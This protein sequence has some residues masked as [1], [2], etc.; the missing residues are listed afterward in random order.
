MDNLKDLSTWRQTAVK[1]GYFMEL[2]EQQ[3][4]TKFRECQT[5]DKVA[6]KA[7]A[8]IYFQIADP[9]KAAYAIDVLPDTLQETCL[10]VLRSTIGCHDFDD[11]FLKRVEINRTVTKE[12]EEKSKSWGIQLREVIIGQVAYNPEVQRALEEKRIA[13]A[14]KAAR[15]IESEAISAAQL[16]ASETRLKI[17]EN[18]RKIQES[19]NRVF[20][21]LVKKVGAA[22]AVPMYFSKK[23]ERLPE[24]CKLVVVPV[25][26]KGMLKVG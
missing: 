26:F 11:L 14:K 16:A 21:D 8:I 12:L 2:A 25:D 7:T 6:I 19:E 9:E 20:E 18:D 1:A 10:H 3:L 15:L 5:R 23:L 13:E 24:S 4:E 17:S 22:A